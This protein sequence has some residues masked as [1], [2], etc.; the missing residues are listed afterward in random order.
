MAGN[1]GTGVSRSGD[2]TSRSCHATVRVLPAGTDVTPAIW[3]THT[4]ADLYPEPFAF[5]P[6]RFLDGGPD[7]APS[8]FLPLCRQSSASRNP[9]SPVRLVFL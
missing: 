7:T 8:A 1:S 4:R 6:E 2:G 9:L 5:R 3:I